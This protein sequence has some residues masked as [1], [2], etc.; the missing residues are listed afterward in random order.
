MS[1][2]VDELVFFVIKTESG[3]NPKETAWLL[4]YSYDYIVR[5]YKRL[6][7]AGKIK[8]ISGKNYEIIE[9]DSY[10]EILNL[11]IIDLA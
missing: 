2:V 6:F 4:D 1:I 5:S 9:P 8:P 7:L 11:S 10:N 3:S